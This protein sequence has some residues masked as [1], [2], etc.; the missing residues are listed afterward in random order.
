MENIKIKIRKYKDNNNQNI[1]T[2]HIDYMNESWRAARGTK[3]KSYMTSN[4]IMVC[5]AEAPAY[6]DESKML[7][8]MGSSRWLDNTN[9]IVSAKTE[10]ALDKKL[11]EIR[12]ALMEW[13]D[14][15]N[16]AEDGEVFMC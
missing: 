3:I 13:S 5:S 16:C 8:L 4:G 6:S 9:I 14:Y 10:S 1:A 15:L 11:A 12:S 7:F 2:I